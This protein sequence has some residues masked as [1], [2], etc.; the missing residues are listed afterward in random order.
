M[1]EPVQLVVPAPWGLALVLGLVDRWHHHQPAPNGLNLPAPLAIVQERATNDYAG[2]LTQ[3]DRLARRRGLG[4]LLRLVP[5]EYTQ[6]GPV[7]AADLIACDY[8]WRERQG[9][10]AGWCWR[11]ANPQPAW[12]SEAA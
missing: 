4:P 8:G 11:I 9:L 2:V 7:G 1:P 6:A 12:R 5:W 10:A 3:V